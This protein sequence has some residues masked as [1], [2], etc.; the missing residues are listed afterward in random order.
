M[1]KNKHKPV[2]GWSYLL[3]ALFSFNVLIFVFCFLFSH[4]VFL[5][6]DLLNLTSESPS[7][8]AFLCFLC[9]RVWPGSTAKIETSKYSR[10]CDFK[11]VKPQSFNSLHTQQISF[12]SKL[13]TWK[14]T[15]Q[16]LA[17]LQCDVPVDFK[18]IISRE[19][20]SS[21]NWII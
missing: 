12:F 2:Y 13:P 17:L 16:S 9:Q 18:P 4:P 7:S 3:S 8:T 21:L 6:V 11:R 10:L 20:S 19:S 5:S 14:I 15:W 1:W